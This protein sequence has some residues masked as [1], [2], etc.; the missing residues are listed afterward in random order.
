MQQAIAHALEASIVIAEEL[1]RGEGA[2]AG[3]VISVG[4]AISF[5]SDSVNIE[6]SHRA[7]VTLAMQVLS[8]ASVRCHSSKGDSAERFSYVVPTLDRLV[9]LM[10]PALLAN[11]ETSAANLQQIREFISSAGLPPLEEHLSLLSCGAKAA[12]L[13]LTLVPDGVPPL[14]VVTNRDASLSHISHQL[15]RE[16]A[17]VLM[18]YFESSAGSKIVHGKRVEGGEGHGPRKEFFMTLTADATRKWSSVVLPALDGQSIPDVEISF[19]DKRIISG[20]AP[21]ASSKV[22]SAQGQH[23]VSRAVA[24]AR[25]GD[26]IRFVFESGTVV[27]RIITAV[28]GETG[29]STSEGFDAL[30]LN[31]S[32]VSSCGLQ[33]P[34]K[35]LFDY[36]RGTGQFWFS[37]YASDL[38][39]PSYGEE[40]QQRYCAFGKL[41]LL[42][43]VN[44]CKIA[45]V[46]PAMF[47]H[48]L[49]HR[50]FQPT[51]EDVKGFD[52]ELYASLKK[53]AKM[54][55]S[56][57]SS[58]KQVEG[59]PE[60]MSRE[61]YVREKIKETFFPEALED[62]R[63]GFLGLCDS[64]RHFHG[65]TEGDLRQVLCPV[66][67]LN[68]K[69]GIRDIFKVEIEDDMKDHEV[70]LK[71][72]W[73]VVDGLP[74]ADKKL[75]LR[76][77]TGLDSLPESG[78]ERLS[79]ELP[80]S[81]FTNEEQLAMLDLLP[82]AH[83]CSN[84]LEIPNY[85]EALK[86]SGK[87]QEGENSKA[88]FSTLCDII[89]SK[90]LTAIR[91]TSGY[92]LDAAADVVA[93][94]ASEQPRADALPSSAPS[95]VSTSAKPA[96]VVSLEAEPVT[97]ATKS[98][99]QN[100]LPTLPASQGHF[101]TKTPLAGAV[102]AELHIDELY[103]PS[104]MANLKDEP[105]QLPGKQQNGSDV[106]TFLAELEMELEAGGLDITKTTLT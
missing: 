51:I 35:P 41:L 99:A 56:N 95:P 66:E 47:F 32:A 43:L 33:R 44:R 42:A 17:C 91:E 28:H 63:K 86:E 89:R 30:S 96:A 36:H 82:Q 102:T 93:P 101:N 49:L 74:L 104:D 75:F 73:S 14:V 60:Q 26:R 67:E 10:R 71:A 83:T 68:D 105:Y 38:S 13:G 25:I 16:S 34:V 53:C 61:E 92:E 19:A 18:P 54:S 78:T 40:L 103:L 5:C 50:D 69:V 12:L 15:P 88:F 46:L 94:A 1:M 77:V 90:L 6:S 20:V 62:I 57:F 45:F 9:L 2:G 64:G 27:E 97:S 72:F 48:L 23:F 65:V 80:F 7:G 70:F 85:Y 87:V 81:A 24:N 3:A 84:T 21:S 58:L 55:D 98:L 79:I 11:I 37:A 106:D 4:H 8:D 29:V 22:M 39:N 59:L 100:H 52:D 76:F 31:G